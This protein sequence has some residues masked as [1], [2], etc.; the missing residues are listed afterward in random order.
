ME[1]DLV[2]SIW[3]TTPSCTR[4]CMLL[5]GHLFLEHFTQIA[6]Q[7]NSADEISVAIFN[8]LQNGFVDDG[9]FALFIIIIWVEE[10][11]KVINIEY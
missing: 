1:D 7:G 6:R 4:C 10:F 11:V 5:Q 8:I 2:N 9:F 3:L